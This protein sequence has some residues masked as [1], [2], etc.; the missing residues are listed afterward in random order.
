MIL[1]I[2][3][4]VHIK[5]SYARKTQ[6]RL[7]LHKSLAIQQGTPKWRVRFCRDKNTL[8]VRIALFDLCS[9]FMIPHPHSIRNY[10]FALK[11]GL[12]SIESVHLIF[13]FCQ[14]KLWKTHGNLV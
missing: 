11:C 13:P 2:C 9:T 4:T 8:L 14:E 10:Q 3:M 12:L 1:L 5:Q 7:L 6:L